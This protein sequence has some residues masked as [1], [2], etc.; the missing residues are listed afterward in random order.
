MGVH[1][2]DLDAETL[3]KLGLGAPSPQPK[4]KPKA[5]FLAE[6]ERRHAINV[7][8]LISKLSQAERRRVLKRALEVNDV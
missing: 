2:D 6:D 5:K 7:L 8:A 1:I 4:A 3:T